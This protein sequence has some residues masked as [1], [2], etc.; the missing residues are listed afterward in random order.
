M[1]VTTTATIEGYRITKYLG[2]VSGEFVLGTGALSEIFAATA[3]FFGANSDSFSSKV[4]TAKKEALKTM[5]HSA[6]MRGATA[7]VGVTVD[8]EVTGNNM[9][10]ASANGTAVM[11]EE[12]GC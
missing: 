5:M 12:C 4:G 10:I 7:V 8:L 1:I 2:I 9:F 3:D 6:F 11:V